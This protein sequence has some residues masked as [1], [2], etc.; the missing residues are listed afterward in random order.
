MDFKHFILK[1]Q[2]M[3]YIELKIKLLHF[4]LS[5]HRPEITAPEH[6]KFSNKLNIQILPFN[7]FPVVLK[8]STLR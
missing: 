3:K 7:F 6:L 4:C 8:Y 1:C 2:Q 5:W